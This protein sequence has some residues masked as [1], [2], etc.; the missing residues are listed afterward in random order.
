MGCAEWSEVDPL[1][2]MFMEE[3]PVNLG[4]RADTQGLRL[5]ENGVG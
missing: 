2:V 5:E 4:S 3:D 1:E